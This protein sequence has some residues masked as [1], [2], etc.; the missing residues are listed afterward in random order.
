[1]C[2]LK[3]DS[4]ASL[5]H[6]NLFRFLVTTTRCVFAC[7]IQWYFWKFSTTIIKDLYTNKVNCVKQKY[8]QKYRQTKSEV[9]WPCKHICI[10]FYKSNEIHSYLLLSL[11][12]RGARR[13]LSF[14]KTSEVWILTS[15]RFEGQTHRYTLCFYKNWN[16]N[17]IFFFLYPKPV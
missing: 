11:I 15:S 2:Q 10:T 16:F 3:R 5:I 9:C 13:S 8:K 7:W 6:N 12:T 17:Y 1:M 4:L 14:R